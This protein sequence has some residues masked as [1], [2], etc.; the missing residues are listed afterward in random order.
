[1][2]CEDLTPVHTRFTLEEMKLIEYLKK[3]LILIPAS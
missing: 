3:D 2:K 1:M